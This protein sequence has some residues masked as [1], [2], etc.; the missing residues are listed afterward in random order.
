MFSL[1]LN[2]MC[3]DLFY[4]ETCRGS[5][6]TFPPDGGLAPEFLDLESLPTQDPYAQPLY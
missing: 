2:A 6:E 5:S 1:L 4:K 3:F